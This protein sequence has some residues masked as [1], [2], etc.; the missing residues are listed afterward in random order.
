MGSYERN[1]LPIA[2]NEPIFTHTILLAI[3][4]LQ[5]VH[6]ADKRQRPL[7]YALDAKRTVQRPEFHAARQIRRR[8][9]LSGIEHEAVSG[10]NTDAIPILKNNI[11]A[12]EHAL[13]LI[14]FLDL[15]ATGHHHGG[16]GFTDFL[17]GQSVR[18]RHE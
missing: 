14:D 11:P 9:P 5:I 4:D 16:I 6:F 13:V 12:F 8:D 3:F 18:D 17:A 10:Y 2:N 7:G 1:R 15:S